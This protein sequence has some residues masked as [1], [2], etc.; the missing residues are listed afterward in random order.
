MENH[1]KP[2]DAE[3]KGHCVLIID[4]DP[5]N[6]GAM[7]GYLGHFGL[8]VLVARDGEVLVNKGY[9]LATV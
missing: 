5:A 9:G 6:L 2:N 7:S 8:E 3:L 4:D 1:L